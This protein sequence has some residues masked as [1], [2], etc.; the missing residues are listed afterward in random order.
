MK[1]KDQFPHF[2]PSCFLFIAFISF[3][4][5]GICLSSLFLHF[6]PVTL[7]F[8]NSSVLTCLSICLSYPVS[9]RFTSISGNAALYN[10]CPVPTFS[11]NAGSCVPHFTSDFNPQIADK[12]ES[13][14]VL[15]QAHAW[16]TTIWLV[17]CVKINTRVNNLM[18][19]V[20]ACKLQIWR[21]EPQ[22]HN[23]PH[24]T[25]ALWKDAHSLLLSLT[26]LIYPGRLHWVLCSFSA[27]MCFKYTH[28]FIFILLKLPSMTSLPL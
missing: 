3:I 14:I 8:V 16:V 18:L 7:I 19:Q 12:F 26:F 22:N 24:C 5:K 21:N 10:L 1:K 4:N 15:S 25:G 6:S 11:A 2:F 9:L 20:T 13:P 17:K 23:V 27:T 28:F